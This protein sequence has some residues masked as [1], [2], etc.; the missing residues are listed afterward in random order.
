MTINR[1]PEITEVIPSIGARIALQNYFSNNDLDKETETPPER[2]L[3]S[4]ST[5][6]VTPS[7]ALTTL[8]S[9]NTS[10][11]VSLDNEA[12]IN[13]GTVVEN[14]VQLPLEISSVNDI[15]DVIILS[16]TN[17]EPAKKKQR[18]EAVNHTIEKDYLRLYSEKYKNIQEKFHALFDAVLN[19]RSKELDCSNK[20]LL[21]MLSG[22]ISN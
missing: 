11:D 5:P 21:D 19:L 17:D 6:S 10:I 13:S 7:E 18:I 20:L 16:T 12:S 9:S 8:M 2:S 4:T 22:N 3:T 1:C 15:Q 14:T